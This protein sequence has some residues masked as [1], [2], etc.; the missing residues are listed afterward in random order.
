LKIY[1]NYILTIAILLLLTTVILIAMNLDSLAIFYEIYILEALIVT[2]LYL[3]FSSK[4]R[5]GL[6]LVAFVLFGGLLCIV[7]LQ[8]I[9]IFV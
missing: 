7:P 3:H 6:N 4:A 2:E 9:K 5:Q 8:V 1:N